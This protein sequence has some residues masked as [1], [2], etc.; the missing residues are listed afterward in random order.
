LAT[1]ALVGAIQHGSQVTQPTVAL[2]RQ[3][4]IEQGPGV[5]ADGAQAGDAGPLRGVE[6]VMD[7]DHLA[8]L[9][10]MRPPLVER[11]L[12]GRAPASAG[13][14]VRSGAATCFTGRIDAGGQQGDALTQG[15]LQVALEHG[16][17]TSS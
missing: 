17:G 3:L 4:R 11:K 12:P 2:I 15:G 5:V 9:D 7:I 13:T 8:A 14:T 16:V 6:L 1:K 10:P